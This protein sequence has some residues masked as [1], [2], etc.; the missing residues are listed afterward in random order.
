MPTLDRT[1]SRTESARKAW[2]K[3]QLSPKLEDKV[4]TAN[5]AKIDADR[6]KTVEKDLKTNLAR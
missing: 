5:A 3:H 6:M 2:K 1:L 4:A